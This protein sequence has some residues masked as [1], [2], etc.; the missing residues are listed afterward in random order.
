M[1]ECLNSDSVF[2]IT[3]RTSRRYFTGVDI[4]EG[5]LLLSDIAVYFLDSRY[6]SEFQNIDGVDIK[7][8]TDFDVIKNEIL[9]HHYKKIYID[10][11]KTSVSEFFRYKTL[12]LD[13]LDGK[14]FIK[15][16]RIIKDDFELD[17]TKKACDIINTAFYNTIKELKQGISELEVKDILEKNVKA[18]GSDFMA[19]DTIVAFGKN[20]AVPHHETSDCKLKYGDVV[21]IDCGCKVD[22]YCSD[23]TRTVFFSG[24]IKPSEKFV[25]CYNAV[26]N[27]NL[28]AE[29]NIKV[30]MLASD[31]DKLARDYFASLFLDKYF[32]HSLGHGVGLDIHEEPY[33]S[34]KG[35]KKIE[36][37]MIFTVE[38]GL[39]FDN[40]FGIRIEDTVAIKDGKLIR[41][42]NDEK[43]L[44]II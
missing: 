37:G 18:L 35:N 12:N 26:L 36:N 16:A 33:V 3:D 22:G 1:L 10:F 25:D 31:C 19:F 43:N 30:N 29:K 6:I 20:S 42:F 5:V 44:I 40:E 34:K 2:I 13:I 28:L 7:L 32:T 11:D 17:C 38:P 24:G 39:Y 15:D 4:A 14:D 8:Y 41:L 27:A 9:S 21:L 23:L